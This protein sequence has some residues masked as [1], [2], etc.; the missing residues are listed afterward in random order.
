MCFNGRLICLL[1]LRVQTNVLSVVLCDWFVIVPFTVVRCDWLLLYIVEIKVRM[2]YVTCRCR[3][4]SIPKFIFFRRKWHAFIQPRITYDE[5]PSSGAPERRTPFFF[6]LFFRFSLLPKTQDMQMCTLMLVQTQRQRWES[7]GRDARREGT[8]QLHKAT[9]TRPDTC[10]HIHA[11]THYHVSENLQVV[12]CCC[13]C[14]SFAE[15]FQ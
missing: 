10:T 4:M 3:A 9:P 6:F 2:R 15:M 5:T 7:K 11:R 1:F 8:T 12:V 13:T 14:R